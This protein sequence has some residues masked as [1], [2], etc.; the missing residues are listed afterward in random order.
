MKPKTATQK[1]M[2]EVSAPVIGIGLVLTAVF[3]PVAFMGGLTGRL[4]QQFALTIAIS[5][6]SVGVQRADPQPGTL[7]PCCSNP[8]SR[9][10]DPSA[11]SSAGSTRSST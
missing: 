3:V 9:R 2:E 7:G 8:P 1:A 6:S 4:Y 5:A 11:C 10:A